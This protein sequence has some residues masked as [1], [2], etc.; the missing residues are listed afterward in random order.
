[1]IKQM[2]SREV[3]ERLWRLLT[4]LFWPS[5]RFTVCTDRQRCHCGEIAKRGGWLFVVVKMACVNGH[6]SIRYV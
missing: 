5:L 1:M 2:K 4:L 6:G 3:G